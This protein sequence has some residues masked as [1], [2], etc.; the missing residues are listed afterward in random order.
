MKRILA[1][2][3]ALLLLLLPLF[4][5]GR[6]K[7]DDSLQGPLPSIRLM[8][9]YDDPKGPPIETAERF[10]REL[11]RKITG[12]E[13]S[14]AVPAPRVDVFLSPQFHYDGWGDA[15]ILMN[16]QGHQWVCPVPFQNFKTFEAA[17]QEAYV[18]IIQLVDDIE[19]QNNAKPKP[20]AALRGAPSTGA[21]PPGQLRFSIF[22]RLS[23]NLF[24]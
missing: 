23:S 13:Q 24:V 22:I 20:G 3:G 14:R 2:T 17:V 4:I 9:V 18:Y 12:Y 19:R 8:V 15:M 10:K 1:A 21:S 7:T 16:W 6:G 5:G 11:E